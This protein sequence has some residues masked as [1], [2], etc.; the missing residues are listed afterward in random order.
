MFVILKY[1]NSYKSFHQFLK[2]INFMIYLNKALSLI[3]NL[4]K[5]LP[6]QHTQISENH[7]FSHFVTHIDSITHKKSDT[8]KSYNHT[9]NTIKNLVLF[10][11]K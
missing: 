1:N 9:K 3:L 10:G 7:I 4:I 5:G 11:K 2:K 8:H 6:N